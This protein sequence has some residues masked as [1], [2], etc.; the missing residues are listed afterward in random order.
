MAVGNEYR[1]SLV[2]L[3][4]GVTVVNTFH[5]QCVVG[6]GTSIQDCEALAKGFENDVVAVYQP[7]ASAQTSFDLVKVRVVTTPNLGYDHPSTKDGTAAGDDMPRQ[8]APEIIWRSSQFGPS[9]RGRTFLFGS[10]EV[11]YAFGDLTSDYI[12]RATNLATALLN[13]TGETTGGYTADFVLGVYSAVLNLF[14]PYVSY[15]IPLYPRTQ[16][17]RRL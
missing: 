11:D 12:T 4:R 2:A 9:Y 8:V 7:L 14:T 5:Y 3:V 13:V 1:L 17:R 10:R 15:Q 6:E 16:R